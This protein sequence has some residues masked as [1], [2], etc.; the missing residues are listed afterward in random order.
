MPGE[1][2]RLWQWGRNPRVYPRDATIGALFADEAAARPGSVA[3]VS[4]G[5]VVSYGELEARANRLAQYLCRRLGSLRDAVVGLLVDRSSDLIVAMLGVLKAGAAYLPLDVSAPSQ[6]LGFMLA[7]AE[8]A[9]VLSTSA[10]AAALPAGSAPV[11]LLDREAAAIAAC[12]ATPPPGEASAES[13]AYVMYTSGSTGRPKGVCVPHRAV[14]RLVKNTDYITIGPGDRIA[15]GSNVAFDAATFEV[16][17]ALLNGATVDALAREELLNPA[18]LARHV[19]ARRF[20]I[21]F[22]TTALF[23]RLADLDAGMFAALDCLLFGG[24]AVDERR[25]A[26]VVA[27]GAPR[28]LLHVYGP[29]ESTTFA[30]WHPVA[31][32]DARDGTIPIGG[33]IANTT[34][35]VL[36]ARGE[37]CPIGVPGELYIGGAGLARGYLGQPALT[38]ERFVAD[39][40]G[41]P[42][43]RLYRSGDYV[44]WRFDGRLEFIGRGDAQEK[45]RGYRI[46]RGEIEAALR[47]D[48][49]VSDAA[50]VVRGAGDA[51][52]LVAYVVP[53]GAAALEVASV[54]G[55]LRAVLPDYMV[56]ARF[57]V[58]DQLPLTANGK[59]DRS[60]LPEP[61]EAAEAA[62]EQ[63]PERLAE[64]DRGG[65]GRAVVGGAGAG[66]DRPDGQLLRAGRS[67]PG[68]DAIDRADPRQ[69]RGGSGARRGVR[70]SGAERAGGGAGAQPRRSDAAG[71][72][73]TPGRG[74]GAAVVRAAAAVVPG[75]TA[76][77]RG[78]GELHH[79]GGAAAGGGAGCGGAA[80][81]AAGADGP[82]G[83]PADEHP[84]RG[85]GA[86]DHAG[87]AV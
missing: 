64:P 21:L 51:R 73:A 39:R 70:T 6:R 38:A 35:Y 25:V 75:A 17:G 60:R 41:P 5:E 57:V 53:R 32:Q 18:V 15:H 2:E 87:G 69:L 14:V 8:A 33:P 3:L 74:G 24:E 63:T 50:V 76:G 22:L 36:D 85:R 16:F 56:P 46:E 29:T 27:A 47:Q 11:I 86:A 82:P 40:F 7:D 37:P 13:L 54:C 62:A 34:A 12:P 58:L 43:G 78:G 26:A 61:A 19:R 45:L 68:G 77:A 79:R 28:H 31:E 84:Q 4:G 72:C 1:R 81:G 71:D 66:P 42:G 67:L 49:G 48:A 83:E 10:L 65:A 44:R 55:R 80:P 30:T 20:N 9:A 23:N 59:L 52:A